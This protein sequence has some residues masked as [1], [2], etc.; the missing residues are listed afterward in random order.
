MI[1]LQELREPLLIRLDALQH[2]GNA[3]DCRLHTRDHQIEDKR[4]HVESIHE[5]GELGHHVAAAEVV[6]AARE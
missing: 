4:L 3:G 5:R 1:L 6:L 2:S